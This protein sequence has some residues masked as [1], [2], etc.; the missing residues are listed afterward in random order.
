MLNEN[1]IWPVNKKHKIK[2]MAEFVSQW[3]VSNY[4]ENTIGCVCVG[5]CVALASAF[6]LERSQ[7]FFLHAVEH[8][9][10]VCVGVRNCSALRCVRKQH[11]VF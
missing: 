3:K 4:A 1:A 11:V 2:Y 6:A 10:C 5:V 8:S 9:V 7:C